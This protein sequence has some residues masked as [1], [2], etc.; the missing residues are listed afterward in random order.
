MDCS[1]SQV[2]QV[3][4]TTLV[5]SRS[6][7]DRI[8]L[9]KVRVRVEAARAHATASVAG[10]PTGR[11]YDTVPDDGNETAYDALEKAYNAAFYEC[12]PERLE[13]SA[14]LDKTLES[15]WKQ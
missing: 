4:M 1:G 3:P 8:E 11:V 13:R 5:H 6:Q 14:L 9:E 15:A 7:T 2:T 12:S 10:I